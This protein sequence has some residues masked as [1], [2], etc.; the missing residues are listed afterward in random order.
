MPT[1][2]TR[3]TPTAARSARAPRRILER[4]EVRVRVDHAAAARVIRASSSAT[5]C[6]GSSLRNSGRGS[7]SGCP[8]WSVLG[9][10][11]AAPAVVV[12]GE[13]GVRGPLLVDLLEA[14]PPAMTSS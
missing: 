1:V 10:Q 11:R 3:V 8:A 13:H 5:T 12:A 14:E 9:S 7:R 6:S 4:I 2:M